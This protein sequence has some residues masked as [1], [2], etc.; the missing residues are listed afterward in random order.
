MR[1]QAC[2]AVDAIMAHRTTLEPLAQGAVQA[3]RLSQCSPGRKERGDTHSTHNWEDKTPVEEPAHKQAGSSQL[4]RSQEGSHCCPENLCLA[5]TSQHWLHPE[6]LH[7]RRIPAHCSAHIA[8]VLHVVRLSA[9]DL[10]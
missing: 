2:W 7:S 10:P 9:R 3:S 6:P 5:Q 1:G 8:D 4:A